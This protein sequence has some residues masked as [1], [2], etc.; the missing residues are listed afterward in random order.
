MNKNPQK[1][2]DFYSLFQLCNSGL[3]DVP[4]S[5]VNIA[6]WQLRAVND[7]KRPFLCFCLAKGQ[8]KKSPR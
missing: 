1:L 3:D 2:Y 8:E 5:N 4:E 7:I 6:D